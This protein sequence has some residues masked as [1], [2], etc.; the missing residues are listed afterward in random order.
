MTD[1]RIAIFGYPRSGTSYLQEIYQTH[2]GWV[3]TINLGEAFV[4]NPKVQIIPLPD[5]HG[6]PHL[7]VKIFQKPVANP[8]SRESRFEL[9]KHYTET[10]DDNY[11]L[12]VL[13]ADTRD[14]R[15]LPWVDANYPIVTISRRNHYDAYLSWIVAHRHKFWNYRQGSGRERPAYTR[16]KA[17]GKN[18]QTAAGVM[19]RYFR[20][21]E[22]IKPRYH[23]WY[24]DLIKMP[25]RKVLE[26]SGVNH[27]DHPAPRPKFVK[28]LTLEQKRALIENLDEVDDYF[29]EKIAPVIAGQY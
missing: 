29:N 14:T 13:A 9:I 1:K 2:L 16:F 10:T 26:L 18:M 25:P 6:V 7:S 12:K 20:F 4:P 24:E 27:R 8:K 11:I 28:L 17:F 15:I 3:G 5:K 19:I 21:V 23:F 22:T